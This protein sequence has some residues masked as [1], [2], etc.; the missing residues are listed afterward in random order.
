M[1]VHSCLK[2]LELDQT[3][4][5][6][7]ANQAYKDIVNVWHPDRFNHNPRLKRK[8]EEKI[9]EINIAYETIKSFMAREQVLGQGQKGFSFAADAGAEGPSRGIKTGDKGTFNGT[10]TNE[11]TRDRT[12]AAFEMGTQL[13]LSAWSYFSSRLR[14]IVETQ[15]I[16]S[17]EEVTWKVKG[18]KKDL[19]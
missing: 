5:I 3:A 14:R 13:I 10:Q 19:E 17:E 11:E 7:D 6:E 12:E 9:K 15:V 18:H 2:I 8:A 4:S 16:D 1:D